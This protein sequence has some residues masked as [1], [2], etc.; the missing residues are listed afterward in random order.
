MKMSVS[1]VQP[2]GFALFG[3]DSDGALVSQDRVRHHQQR[4]GGVFGFDL[5]PSPGRLGWRPQESSQT[6]NFHVIH[7]RA[8]SQARDDV[9][10]GSTTQAVVNARS[11]SGGGQSL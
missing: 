1:R 8:A 5:L 4:T 11:W 6:S 3:R 2:V 9:H 10:R 7:T